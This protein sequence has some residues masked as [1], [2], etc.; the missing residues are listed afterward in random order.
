MV[1]ADELTEVSSGVMTLC[2]LLKV[3][4]DDES[5]DGL[6]SE[7]QLKIFL[8]TSVSLVSYLHAISFTFLVP[9]TS[10]GDKSDTDQ[11]EKI[12]RREKQVVSIITHMA[13]LALHISVKAPISIQACI[14]YCCRK[15]CTQ[16]G[17][18]QV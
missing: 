2:S 6:L 12:K 16:V 14:S 7:C 13:T 15:H 8:S 1:D 17:R 9:F 3:E 4:D 5:H 18:R 11:N 10:M